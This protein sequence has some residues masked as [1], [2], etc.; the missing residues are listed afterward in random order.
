M[1]ID[2]ALSLDDIRVLARKRLPRI[3]YDFIEGGADDECCLQRNRA[4]FKRYQLVPRYL[5]DVSRR[6]QSVTLLGRRYGSAIGI[7]PTGLAGMFRRGADCML[8]QA[9]KEHDIPFLLSSQS[10]DS[11]ETV[12]RIAPHH[13]WFQLY[14][15]PDRRINRDLVRR[16]ADAGVQVLV[17]SVDV[18]VAANRVRNRRNGFT[19]PFRLTPRIA[20][21]A[22]ARPGWLWEYLRNGGL[23]MMQ[24]W[25]PYAP[26]DA[27]VGQVADLFAT[28][29]PN[30]TT[31]WDMVAEIRQQWPGALVLKG[32]LDPADA[33]R[34]ADSGVDAII[35]S[36]HGGRQLDAA[37]API[38]MLPSIRAA[39]PAM[40]LLVDSGLRRGSD[41]VIALCLG[42][43]FTFFGRPT[44]Y[45][46]AAA[47]L[48]G[49]RKA[50]AIVR[51]EIDMVMAQIGCNRVDAL[52]AQWLRNAVDAPWHGA[53]PAPRTPDGDAPALRTTP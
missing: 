45:G 13:V 1:N 9:A 29:T 41:I 2:A 39:V 23:P 12:A 40:P 18:P 33:R 28:L 26:P 42:A 43:G 31:S 50:L 25:L 36:N 20:L 37:P 10:N 16:A 22:L 15:T 17:V 48:D 49:V 14:C 27:T 52:D 35:V 44:L 32:I 4:V 3:A 24:N 53:T 11:I 7:A 30:P 46:A 5:R 19:R 8:A 38:D 47:G 51:A 34:A 21:Q 6:D